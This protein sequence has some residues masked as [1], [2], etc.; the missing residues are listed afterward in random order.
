MLLVFLDFFST[1]V[2][3]VISIGFDSCATNASCGNNDATLEVLLL[4]MDF[5]QRM[6]SE[7][8]FVSKY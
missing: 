6:F 7:D 5:Y 4:L 2:Y 1:L 3:D 8:L